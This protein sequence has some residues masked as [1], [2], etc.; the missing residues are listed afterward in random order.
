MTIGSGKF[1]LFG[2]SSW[3]LTLRRTPLALRIPDASLMKANRDR[4]SRKLRSPSFTSN[5]GEEGVAVAGAQLPPLGEGG[6]FQFHITDNIPPP[7]DLVREDAARA[8]ARNHRAPGPGGRVTLERALYVTSRWDWRALP[9]KS[10]R[11]R[12][13]DE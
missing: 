4:L 1:D 7:P 10:K 8:R 3:P 13:Q 2:V 5:H 9:R 12:C 6:E 11:K